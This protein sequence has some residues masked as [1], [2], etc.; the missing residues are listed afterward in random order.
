MKLQYVANAC[1]L[2]TLA[3]GRRLLTDPWYRGPCQQT[4]WNFPP[5]HERLAAEIDA[6]R[7]DFLYISHLHHDH[8]HA[9]TLAP[10][11]R[12]TPVIVGAMSTPNLKSA[13]AALGFRTLIE[14]P[15]ETRAPLADTGAQIVLFKD[16]HGNTQGDDTQV[17]YDLDTS[18]YLIDADGTRL[19]LAVDN[20]IL[21]ADAARI[22][23]EY[24]PPDIAQVPYVSASL[25]PMAMSDYDDAAKEAAMRALRRRA[26]ANFG[27]VTK[28]LGAGR[29]IPAGGEYVLGGPAAPLSRFLPQPLEPELANE[30]ASIDLGQTLAKLYP[31][32]EIDSATLE[33]ARDAEAAYRGFTDADRAAYAL[34]LADRPPSL[35]ELMLPSDTAFDWSRALKKCAANYAARRERMGLAPPMDV[36]LD[37]LGAGGERKLLF[38]YALDSAACGMV[39][40]QGER[41]RLTYRLD[42]RLLFCLVTGLVSWNAMEASALI[43]VSRQPDVYVHDLHRSMVHFTLLS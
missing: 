35:T 11:D 18:L 23:A 24:G 43:G 16:F 17:A 40:A 39:E 32:D 42:A 3:S 41:A 8:V 29:A 28:A 10:F 4:W 14:T 26:A 13:L 7:P 25:F 30:L 6:C 12:A 1:F 34:T 2:I 37:V 27:A 5:V 38:R 19:F 22:A 36:Y 9:E 31:G 33:I 21:P 15:F 20:T